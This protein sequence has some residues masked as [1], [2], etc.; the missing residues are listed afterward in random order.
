LA[1]AM[2]H[3]GFDP[4]FFFSPLSLSPGVIV[5][6]FIGGILAV[7]AAQ[8][9][10]NYAF[11]AR[12]WKI[13][14]LAPILA[15][16]LIVPLSTWTGTLG[17]YAKTAGLTAEPKLALISTLTAIPPWVGAIGS[18]AIFAAI[19]STADSIFFAAASI[20]AK[21]LMQRW[22][23]PHADDKTVLGWTRL[24][25][26]FVGL[27]ATLGAMTVP[28]LL[29]QAYFVYSL[30][31]VTLV[32][33]FMGIYYKRAHPDAAFWSI[34]AGFLAATLYQFK[35]PIDFKAHVGGLHVATFTVLVAIPVFVLISLIRKWTP[36]TAENPP[37][38]Y[39]KER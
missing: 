5:G 27:L 25:T 29:K 36:E 21:D 31:A 22:W 16:F 14:R 19:I 6:F 39:S 34:I 18:L 2:Q 23:R 13:A 7:P 10:V 20:L 9:T 33:V 17:L 37:P 1:A 11:G 26:L 3:K 32:C 8:A 38:L 35:I 30:R 12:N 24:C 15:A 4:E 28:E